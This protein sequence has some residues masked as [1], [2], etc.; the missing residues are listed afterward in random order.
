MTAISSWSELFEK[1]KKIKTLY[2]EIWDIS[3]IK[4]EMD[5]LRRLIMDGIRILEIGAGDRRYEDRIKKNCANGHI[6]ES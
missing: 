5:L 6:Q 2:P 3:L 1:R 4:K